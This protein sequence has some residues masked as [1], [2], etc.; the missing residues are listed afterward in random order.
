MNKTLYVK[1]CD[2]E[3]WAEAEKLAPGGL[4]P[5]V[6]NLLADYVKRNRPPNGEGFERIVVEVR[7]KQFGPVVKKAF[8]G[9]WLIMP[10][11]KFQA[12]RED[13][14]YHWNRGSAFAVAQ[15]KAGRIAVYK[16][17]PDDLQEESSCLEVYE[18]YD[19]FKDARV[20]KYSRYPENLVAAV[21]TALG[22]PYEIDLDI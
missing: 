12:E 22:H 18:N 20:D 14:G 1:D 13:S 15:T 9:R 16:F 17:V 19:D 6:T 10:G 8:T 2:A 21:S 3:V 5:L 4:S 11:D 7:Q